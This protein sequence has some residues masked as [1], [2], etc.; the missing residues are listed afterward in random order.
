MDQEYTPPI[1]SAVALGFSGDYSPPAGNVVA[2]EFAQGSGPVGSTQYLFPAAFDSLAVGASG[3]RW[4][5]QFTSPVGW[6]S[7]NVGIGAKVWNYNQVI[8]HGGSDYLAAGRPN[9]FLWQRYVTP[10]GLHS[11][12]MGNASV[13]HGVRRVTAAGGVD[14]LRLGTAWVSRSPRD[15]SPAG[16][17]SLVM[18]ESHTVG[19]RRYINPVGTEMT[20]W[21]ERII[22][23]SQTVGPQGFAGEVGQPAVQN[24][25]QYVKPQGFALHAQEVL[26]F[27]RAH[28]WNLRQF[29]VQNY[30]PADGLNPPG[31]GQWTAIEN[32]NKTIGAQGW[33][34]E[35]HGYTQID[36]NARL[37]APGG[38][39]PPSLPEYQKTGSVTHRNRPQLLDGFDSAVV[40]HWHAIYNNAAIVG[41]Y[42]VD[43][44]T[45]GAPTIE[46][47]SREYRN[48]GGMDVMA[49]GKPMVSAGVRTLS[50]EDRYTIEPPPIPLPVVKLHTRYVE[51]VSG[52]D[53][54]S[55]G[56]AILNIRWTTIQPRWTHKDLFGEPTL[57]KVTP[58]LY[59][60]GANH[61]EFGTASIRTQWRRIETAEGYMTQWGRP[62]V[63][64]R[65]NW[66][67]LD[68][69]MPPEIPRPTVTKQGGLPEVQNIVA[70]G[71]DPN[72]DGNQVP[73]PTVSYL[74]AYPEGFDAMK[75]GATVVTANSIRV[76]PGISEY[77]MGE[78]MVTL[79]NRVLTV[80]DGIPAPLEV[81]APR[82]SPH[83][84]YA[85]VEAPMQA[86]RNHPTSQ[87]HY[88]DHS[89]ATNELLKGPG[90]PRIE[91]R[92]RPVAPIWPDSETKLFGQAEVILARHYVRPEGFQMLRV[93]MHSLPG[94]QDIET[95][96]DSEATEWGKPTV[97]FAPYL[98]PQTIAPKGFAGE[99]GSDTRA[100]FK[101]RSLPLAGW[102]S[103]AMGA[104]KPGDTPYAWQGLRV[105]PL[106]PT[107]PEGFNAEQ[108]GTAW[109]SHR[110]RNL[111]LEGFDSFA[112]E[113]DYQQFE[114]R[115]R[116]KNASDT[117]K[118]PAQGI[119]A[120]G[121]AA[122]VQVGAPDVRPG[123]YFIRPDGN[124]EQYRKGAF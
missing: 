83:T 22:P 115:M 9:V 48:V 86:M 113:Y 118:P 23:I 101:N 17:S 39:A 100:E 44:L 62:I 52:G 8:K 66:V 102:H 96:Q 58:E 114:K 72:K 92:L 116:V 99:M 106:M 84:I 110:V 3:V 109:V 26:R 43:M 56:G 112:C 21:G 15:V 19:G 13:T 11:L 64:D 120:A 80:K 36:N 2:L 7:S 25:R 97:K 42:G 98:G 85:V 57:R 37:L 10:T 38:I 95:F 78:P 30:D 24:M 29:I 27:G 35:R 68:G 94:Q 12:A 93:G 14:S 82:L 122:P 63:R 31:F 59:A 49:V 61:E 105:G 50:F 20:Q 41:P 88:V 107:I 70:Q 111:P 71:I 34:S 45:T 40:S 6:G 18:L 46:N 77:L 32:R 28:A 16:I 79:K 4:A 47:R 75:F 53:M 1:G 65:R 123:T 5:Q 108:H 60:Q 119:G 81:P 117:T 87:L 54:S 69:L 55:V 89:P 121:I 33:A 67:T 76:D 73:R 124:A 90:V 91:H 74:F 103:L 104:S 51:Q